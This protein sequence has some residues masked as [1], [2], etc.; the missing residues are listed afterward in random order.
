VTLLFLRVNC[1]D[2]APEK[3]GAGYEK[4]KLDK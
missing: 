3:I 2:D 1:T 4:L